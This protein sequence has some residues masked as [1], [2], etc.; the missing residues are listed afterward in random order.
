MLMIRIA[1]SMLLL[2][3]QTPS[4]HLAYG[5][6]GQGPAERRLITREGYA[7]LHDSTRKS[8]LWVSYRL[9]S[10]YTAEA[11]PRRNQFAPDPDLP[12]GSRAELEDYKSVSSTWSRGHLCPADDMKRNSTVMRECFYLSN[13]VPQNQQMNGGIWSKLESRMQSYARTYGDVTIIVGPIYE[14]PLPGGRTAPKPVGPNRVHV[15]T[16]M[17]RI[18]VRKL[19]DGG[20]SVLAFELPNEKISPATEANLVNY[21]VSVRQIE[22]DTGLNFLNAL[23]K[24]V[25]DRIETVKPKTLWP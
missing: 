22:K 1:V 5:A 13:M 11:V 6:P 14:K 23:P 10:A 25:Q 8:A 3:Q 21:L 19:P 16:W 2:A 18:V 9:T 17:Y 12:R 7:L 15:P 4:E 24:S 20:W